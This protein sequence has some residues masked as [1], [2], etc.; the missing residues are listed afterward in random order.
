[1]KEG[2][3]TYRIMDL[4]RAERPRERLMRL[5]PG[6]LKNEELLAILFRTGVPGE[7]AVQVG[8]RLL[9][10]FGGLSG[11]HRASFDEVRAQH[12]IGAA[13]ACQ[14]KAAIELGHRLRV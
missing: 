9:Q 12:G 6:P 8:L 13:K 14:I 3:A 5:G 1:M 4:D 11:L 7:N 2:S 10:E